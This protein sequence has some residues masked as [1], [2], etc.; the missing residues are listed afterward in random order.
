MKT[1]A[2][3]NED[4]VAEEY[5]VAGRI[6]GRGRRTALLAVMPVKTAVSA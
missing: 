1:V 3:E 2:D 6:H 5:A 4:T